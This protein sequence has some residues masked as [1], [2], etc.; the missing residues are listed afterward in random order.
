MRIHELATKNVH[1]M[2]VVDKIR[3]KI[4]EQNEKN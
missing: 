2:S 4:D 3:K 1:F